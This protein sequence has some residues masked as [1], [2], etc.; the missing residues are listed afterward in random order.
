MGEIICPL[1]SRAVT[2]SDCRGNPGDR[3][4]D[5]RYESCAKG[6]CAW[7]VVNKRYIPDDN[8]YITTEK[9]CAIR[10]LAERS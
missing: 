7:W 3:V 4:A 9:G 6:N 2:V 5:M 8:T 1:M 10:L